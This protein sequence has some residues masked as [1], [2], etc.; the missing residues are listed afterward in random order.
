MTSKSR[1]SGEYRRTPR[2]H[3]AWL[4]VALALIGLSGSAALWML[5]ASRPDVADPTEVFVMQVQAAAK[6]ESA[7]AF[8]ALGG[9][10][11]SVYANGKISVI[12]AD[13]PASPCVKAGWRLAKTG[14]VIVNGVL[15]QRLSAARLTELCEGSAT[16]TWIPAN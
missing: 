5:L 6:G 14:T 10:L 7:P 9:T 3:T 12:A 11:R 8:H 13:V 1:P 2:P 16:L 4:P 15:A